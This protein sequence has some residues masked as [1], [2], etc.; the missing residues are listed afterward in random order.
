[1]SRTIPI[2]YDNVLGMIQSHARHDDRAFRQKAESI[3]S[4]LCISNRPGEAKLLRD[5][6]DGFNSTNGKHVNTTLTMMSS[7][8]PANRLGSVNGD[9]LI[10]RP[11]R[12]VADD[13]LVLATPAAT[14]LAKIVAE[15]QNRHRL[16]EAG[17]KPV[18]RVLFWGPPGCGKTLAAHWLANELNL[19]FGVVR[20]SAVITS[21]VG[22]TAANLQK[23]FRQANEMPQVLLLDEADAVAKKRDS[24]NDVDELKRVVNSLL[25]NMDELEPGKSIVVF[26]SN[27]QQLFDSAIWRRFDDVVEFSL[28]GLA[29]R[30]RLLK[31]LTSGL[32][33]SGS[34]EIVAKR[35]ANASFA[36]I[37]RMCAEV[38]KIAVLRKTTTTDT[39][40]LLAIWKDWSGK[41]ANAASGTA[42]V[43]SSKGRRKQG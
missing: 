39:K 31:R 6:L 15:Y 42:K 8:I 34:L 11:S 30:L 23:I 14:A 5:S 17:L 35:T 22:E 36:D 38:A 18:S 13:D 27:H 3:I 29:E 19:P 28:P 40:A 21:Y 7:F 25:Q 10:S 12:K 33:L 16:A 20:L 9:A 24:R 43:N 32:K 41:Q 1:M 26:A 37:A 4:E 2:S